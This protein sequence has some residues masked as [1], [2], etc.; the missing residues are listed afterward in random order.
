MKI[1]SF[2]MKK[3]W[4]TFLKHRTYISTHPLTHLLLTHKRDERFIRGFSKLKN[5]FWKH[6]LDRWKIPLPEW[7][8]WSTFFKH[9]FLNEQTWNAFETNN[10]IAK[11]RPNAPTRTRA[12]TPGATWDAPAPASAA[13]APP[14][15][16]YGLLTLTLHNWKEDLAPRDRGMGAL[17]CAV[18]LCFFASIKEIRQPWRNS[19][20]TLRSP[21]LKEFFKSP[22]FLSFYRSSTRFQT[23]KAYFLAIKNSLSI[24]TLLTIKNFIKAGGYRK[25]P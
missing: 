9:L 5:V 21:S 1:I 19:L 16:H 13:P 8:T 20:T 17:C 25:K 11:C 18:H 15:K 24:C 23:R 10:W 7:K 6:C 22:V 2:W 3:T 14:H 12:W 4:N